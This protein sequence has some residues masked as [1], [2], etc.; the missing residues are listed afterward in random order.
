[1]SIYIEYK[2]IFL[3]FFVYIDL[4]VLIFLGS[5]CTEKKK[6]WRKL[7]TGEDADGH[8]RYAQHA[9][10]E[11]VKHFAIVPA[12]QPVVRSLVIPGDPW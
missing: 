9:R 11:V 5:T 6:S 10:T 3:S 8:A 12:T 4:S 7:E 1:M 2:I